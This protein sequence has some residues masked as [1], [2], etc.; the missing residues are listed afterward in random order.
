LGVVL[1]KAFALVLIPVLAIALL[2]LPISAAKVQLSSE[3]DV[4]AASDNVQITLNAIADAYVNDSDPGSNFGSAANLYV[5]AN[6]TLASSYI[7]FDLTSIPL[8][9]NIVSANFTAYLSDTGGDIYWSPADSIGAYYCPDN[10]WTEPGITWNNKPSLNPNPTSSYSFSLFILFDYKSWD[11]TADVKTALSSGILTEVLK[12][13]TK[14]GDGYAL[15]HSREGANKPKLEIEY[16]PASDLSN[17]YTHFVLN[18]VS[19]IYPSDNTTKPLGCV[20]AW[21][22]DWMASAF[23][24]T[25]LQHYTEGLDTDSNFV[26]QTSGSPLNA[27]GQGIV[28]FGGPV[29]NPVVKYAESSGTPSADRAPIRFYSEGSI[30]YFQHLNGSSIPGASLPVS[31]VNNDQDMFVMEIYTDGSG[32]HMMLCY[33]FGWKGTYAAGKYFH[34]TVYPNSA[35]YNLGWIV[36][37]WQDA[38]DDGFVNNPGDGDN[39][40]IIAFST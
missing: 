19:V 3:F 16:S 7:K 4:D 12:F 22:S 18:N 14:T 5:S 31:V 11:V 15:F 32:R 30:F 8:G 38:N 39:Y 26:D 40:T 20:A 9:V 25:K 27:S 34:T 28:S 13:A 17:F 23:V 1:K 35:S 10:S 2:L 37:K 36:V 21:V 24:T 6:S 29:V 33:G